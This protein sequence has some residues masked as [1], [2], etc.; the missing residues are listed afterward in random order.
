MQVL[1][2]Y[3][4][5]K[6]V[7]MCCFVISSEEGG[8]NH[9]IINIGASIPDSAGQQFH[10]GENPAKFF[11]MLNICIYCIPTSSSQAA[12]CF[13]VLNLLFTL[14][15]GISKQVIAHGCLLLNLDSTVI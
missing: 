15:I 10:Q 14:V 7:A 3:V 9:R 11:I 2:G 1:E 6:T 4:Q 5:R 12:K 8:R 13:T